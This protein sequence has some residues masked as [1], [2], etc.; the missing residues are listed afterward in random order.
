MSRLD[1][2]ARATIRQSGATIAGYTRHHFRDGVWHGDRC[3]CSDDRCVGHHHDDHDE[4][5]CLPV[6][7]EQ[8][9]STAM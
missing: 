7:L 3:G 5:R 4:C 9:L 1:R 2:A 6:L 8:Y